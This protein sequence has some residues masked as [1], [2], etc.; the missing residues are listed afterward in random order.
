M[1]DTQA[2]AN[3]KGSGLADVLAELLAKETGKTP[4]KKEGS[5]SLGQLEEVAVAE[6][7]RHGTAI[8]IP[9]D[10]TLEQAGRLIQSRMKY[11]EQEVQLVETIN[12]FP[13]D[14][15]AAMHRVLTRIYGWVQGVPQKG[16]FSDTPPTMVQV[17][18]GPNQTISVPWGD[19]VL[20]G[21]DGK[22]TTSYALEKDLLVFM[23][24]AKVKQKHERQIRQLFQ[25]VREEV[26]AH[27]LYRGKALKIRFLDNM[28]R[29]KAIPDISFMDTSG[30][31]TDSA[32]YSA[33]VEQ[34][35]NRDLY[36]PIA[37][38]HD[39]VRNNIPLKRGVLLTGTY[40]TGK[41]LAATVAAALATANG[42]PFIYVPRAY[43]LQKAIA[44]ARQYQTP[45]AVVFVED[46]D[47]VTG[48]ERSVRMDDILNIIDGVD[49]KTSNII[50]VLTTND[51]EAINPAMIRP[52]RLD[53]II[54]VTPPDAEAVERLV[55]RFAGSQLAPGEDLTAVGAKLA[56]TI[57]AVIVEVVR[58]AKLAQLALQKPGSL[59]TN[60]TAK[61]LLG[62]AESMT[63]QIEILRKASEKKTVTEGKRYTDLLYSWMSGD[64][65]PDTEV[66]A[67]DEGYEDAD[68]DE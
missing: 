50:V 29:D 53:S 7:H 64:S 11:E 54:D 41:T 56:G 43:E 23:M 66:A 20:P 21:I 14:G 12:V 37:R 65:T 5:K 47:R 27:S 30:V 10:M 38:A 33:N 16:F 62:A 48:G 2:R 63:N 36:V 49:G 18:V 26:T 57:P 8:T 51:L 19:F 60:L 13:W 28:G 46:I 25:Q 61:G 17:E 3:G 31:T 35:L 22:I 58:R 52:G 32:I 6:I 45:A 40:G 9:E 68:S 55:R 24:S 1:S 39:L 59:V 44:F 34:Q 67:R 42:I 4:T 15:A